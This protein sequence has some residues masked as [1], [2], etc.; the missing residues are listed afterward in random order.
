MRGKSTVRSVIYIPTE[1]L[2]VAGRRRP[3]VDL[4]WVAK[5]NTIDHGNV[6]PAAWNIGKILR[7]D[8]SEVLLES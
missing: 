5:A 8:E 3:K 6:Q 1:N 7:E 4:T 2:I